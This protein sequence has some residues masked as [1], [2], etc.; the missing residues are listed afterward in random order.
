MNPIYNA[1]IYIVWFFATYYVVVFTLMLLSERKKIFED[2][3]K[4]YNPKITVSLIVPA[5]NEEKKIAHT[6]N[7]L[8]KVD[9]PNLEILIINDGSS[10]KTSSVVKKHIKGDTRFTFIDNKKNKGKAACLNQGI[11]LAKGEFVAC[12][13]ADSVIEPDTFKKTIPYFKNKKVGAVTISVE[14]K[15]PKNIF[16][17]LIE[18]E[19]TIGLSLFLKLA[20]FFRTIFVTPG[21]FSMY[22]KSVL[23]EIGGFDTQNITEDLE[24]AY[25]IHKAGYIIENCSEAKVYTIIPPTFKEIYIQ[26]RRWYSGAI[27]TLHKHRD[28]MFK[29]KYGFFGFLVPYNYLLTI[30]GLAVFFT[31]LYLLGKKTFNFISSLQYTGFNIIQWLKDIN[32]D[33]RSLGNISFIGTSSLFIIMTILIISLIVARKNLSKRKLGIVAFPA[34]FFLYQIFWTGAIIN[35]I[36]RKKIKWR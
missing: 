3:T 19:F 28:M 16:H 15:D 14:V 27:Q 32:F 33:Y 2:R 20:T 22:R 12:M 34:M 1:F 36:R 11:S 18:L 5:F 26:R 7:S 6:I 30:T 9:H 13:D 21:P 4:F 17:K 29:K 35:I 10:D 25:R 23:K 8:K 24:I 31:S